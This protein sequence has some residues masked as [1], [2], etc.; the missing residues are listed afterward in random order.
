MT[1]TELKEALLLMCFKHVKDRKE[2]I[3]E[4]I[5]AVED[6]MKMEEKSSA[7]DKHNTGRA[8]LQLQRE[9]I[10]MHLMQVENIEA[11]LHRVSIYSA[12]GMVKLGSLVTTKTANYFLSISAGMVSVNGSNYIC[13]SVGSPIG[14][15][16]M[17]KKKGDSFTFSGKHVVIDDVH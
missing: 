16:L 8:M 10:G 12:N 7:G 15:L 4:S 5:T 13:I 3:L 17:G 11:I 6:S 2:R 14:Q 1:P 9:N